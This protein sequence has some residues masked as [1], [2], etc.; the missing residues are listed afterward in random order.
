VIPEDLKNV[1]GLQK[2]VQ[3]GAIVEAVSKI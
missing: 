1:I 3:F 2:P